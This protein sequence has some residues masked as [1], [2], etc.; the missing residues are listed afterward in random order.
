MNVVVTGAGGRIGFELVRSIRVA[1]DE[2][3]AWVLPQDPRIDDLRAL[4]AEVFEGALDDPAS[5]RA[6]MSGADAVCHLAAALTTHGADDATFMAANAV[7]TFTVLSAVRE[8]APSLRRFVY[9]S[10]DAVYWSATGAAAGYLPIDETH[11]LLSGS[12]YG[13]TKVAAEAL[14]R[15][16]WY[17]YGIPFSIVRPTA[18]ALPAELVDPSSP[19]G[20][21]WFVGGALAWL[22]SRPAPGPHDAALVAELERYEDGPERL[23]YLVDAGGVASVTML[24]HPSDVAAGMHAIMNHPDAAG[25][26]FNVGA[27]APVSERVLVQRLAERLD[28]EAVAITHEH[29]RPSW[30]VSSAKARSIA[31]YDP[32][33]TIDDMISAAVPGR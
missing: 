5:L 14:C 2:V 24:A 29:L 20:R 21:R 25:E 15:S 18:T 32:Q 26:A 13:A 4:G 6:P 30:H 11:P 9:V 12:V 23:F 33:V 16:H 28:I 8:H 31:G 27:P 1:G 22:R 19:F 17:S 3:R 10:S 7:G